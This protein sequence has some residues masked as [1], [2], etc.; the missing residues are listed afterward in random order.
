MK[1]LWVIYEQCIKKLFLVLDM[2]FI[3]ASEWNYGVYWWDGVL[4]MVFIGAW[5]WN[6]GVY[7]SDGVFDIVFIGA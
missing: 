4:D 1:N 6:D 2:V 3:G 7:W 5:E